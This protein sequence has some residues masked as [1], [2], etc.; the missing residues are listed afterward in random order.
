MRLRWFFFFLLVL[1]RVRRGER[2]VDFGVVF[3]GFE[4]E[5]GNDIG[6]TIFYSCKWIFG[7]FIFRG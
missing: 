2:F 4:G 1:V 6:V 7:L 5:F 3:G